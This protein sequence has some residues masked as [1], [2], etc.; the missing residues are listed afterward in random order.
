MAKTPE[1]PAGVRKL[2]WAPPN[3]LASVFDVFRK[4]LL[5]F[6]LA[7]DSSKIDFLISPIKIGGSIEISLIDFQKKH[8]L[9][10][11]LTRNY[12]ICRSDLFAFAT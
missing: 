7:A 9:K 11:W 1:K 2:L 5:R 4:V 12:R 3:I 8:P 10:M 6:S